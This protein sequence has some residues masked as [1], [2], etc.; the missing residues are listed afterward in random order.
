MTAA[1]SKMVVKKVPAIKIN[2][3]E[4][5]LSS[6]SQA[7]PKSSKQQSMVSLISH[8]FAGKHS[9]S[10]TPNSTRNPV[11]P[12][13]SRSMLRSSNSMTAFSSQASARSR[14]QGKTNTSSDQ[15][16]TMVSSKQSHNFTKRRFSAG[17]RYCN[18]RIV[19]GK[20]MSSRVKPI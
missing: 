5:N 15:S 3:C 19:A 11:Q 16:D 1:P 13:S 6:S 2:L 4:S 8:Q 17:S 20:P 14:S 7:M 9:R 18:S 12:Q 10:K